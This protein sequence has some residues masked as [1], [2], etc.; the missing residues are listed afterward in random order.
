MLKIAHPA[1]VADLIDHEMEPGSWVTVDQQTIDR[2]AEATGDHQWIH[3]DSERAERELPGGK[4][5][6]H[7]YLIVSLLPRLA[8][9][10]STFENV[11]RALNYGSDRVRFT[12]MVTVGSRVRLRKTFKSLQK[13]ENGGYRIAAE[14]VMEIEGEQRPAV[15]AEVISLVFP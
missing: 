8:A 12:N 5:I 15:M 7:G 10:I 14:C 4:T 3:V 2:F 6:A 11:S 1:D 13:Q 9:E